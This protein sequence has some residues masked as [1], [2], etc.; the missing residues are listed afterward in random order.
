MAPNVGSYEDRT[1]TDSLVAVELERRV[2]REAQAVL[3]VLL[4]AYLKALQMLLAM[5]FAWSILIT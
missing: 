3:C 1:V 2:G 5:D 4:R